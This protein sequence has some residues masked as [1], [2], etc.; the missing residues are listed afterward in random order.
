MTTP[1]T[2][3]V[4]SRTPDKE[5]LAKRIQKAIYDGWNTQENLKDILAFLAELDEDDLVSTGIDNLA[6]WYMGGDPQ[7]PQ[8]DG[9]PDEY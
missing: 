2:T 3:D 6:F 8:Y 7:V 4:H 9:Y 1:R 5:I